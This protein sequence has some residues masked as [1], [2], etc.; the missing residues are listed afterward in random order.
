MINAEELSRRLVYYRAIN[1]ISITDL[2]KQ[3]GIS[4]NTLQKIIKKQYVKE[5]PY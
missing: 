5:S 3:L 1:K 4:I 2:A